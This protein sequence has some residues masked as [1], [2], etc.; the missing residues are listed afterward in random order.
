[1]DA[2]ESSGRSMRGNMETIA[3]TLPTYHETTILLIE[4]ESTYGRDTRNNVQN[5]LQQHGRQRRNN[6]SYKNGDGR[7]RRSYISDDGCI[8]VKGRSA[9]NVVNMVNFSF[10]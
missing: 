6:T 5:Q 3:T 10:W 4:E 8:C 1:M 7:G 2:N 9:S